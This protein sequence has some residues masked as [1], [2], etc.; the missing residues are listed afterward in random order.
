M[1]F[2]S[3]VPRLLKKKDSSGLTIRVSDFNLLARR[4]EVIKKLRTLTLASTSGM[5]FEIDNL[6]DLIKQRPVDCKVIRAYQDTILVGWGILSREN[7]DFKFLNTQSGFSSSQGVL[8]QLYVHPEYRRKGIGTK[9][10]EIAKKKA[11]K[12]SICFSPWNF[13]SRAFFNNFKKYNPKEL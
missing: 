4:P 2:K 9:I 7:S 1:N 8:F 3:Y 5:N 12:H 11:G 13:S 6:L 10:T